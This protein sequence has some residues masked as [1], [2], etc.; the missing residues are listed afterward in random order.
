VLGYGSKKAAGGVLTAK[1]APNRPGT[2]PALGLRAGSDVSQTKRR[3]SHSSAAS[4]ALAVLTVLGL[5]GPTLAQQ[6]VPFKG[7][8]GRGC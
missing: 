4:L 8:L 3:D 1:Q 7:S 2:A 6:Q 5:A